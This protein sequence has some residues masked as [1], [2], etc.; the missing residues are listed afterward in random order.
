MTPAAD[1]LRTAGWG[2]CALNLDRADGAWMQHLPN[3]ADGRL[4]L[5]IYTLER[6]GE[7]KEGLYVPELDRRLDRNDWDGA[8]QAL[9]EL[10]QGPPHD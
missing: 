3:R 6:G 10:D 4:V 5:H 2:P 7:E 8:A 9:Q 1:T